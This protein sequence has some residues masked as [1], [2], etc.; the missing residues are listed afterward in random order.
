MQNVTESI[1]IKSSTTGSVIAGSGLSVEI[2]LKSTGLPASIFSDSAGTIPIT[3]PITADDSGTFSF[4]AADGRYQAVIS[5]TGISGTVTKEFLL[6]DVGDA[7]PLV[8]TTVDATIIVATTSIDTPLLTATDLATLARLIAGDPGTEATGITINGVLYESTAKVSDIDGTHLAQTILHR[9]STVLEPLIVGARSNGN[10]SAHVDVVAGQGLFTV[11]AAGY[12]GTDYKLFGSFTFGA[13]TGTISNT[14]APGSWSL[15]L[16]PDGATFPV[17]VLALDNAGNI[18]APGFPKAVASYTH[19]ATNKDTPVDADEFNIWDSVTGLLNKVTFANLKA[20]IAA[21]AINIDALVAKTIPV[22]ADE[23]LLADSADTFAAKKLTWAQLKSTFIAQL[24][25][26][27]RGYTG[28]IDLPGN[29]TLQWGTAAAASG[30]SATVIFSK[31][32]G[33]SGAEYYWTIQ[34]SVNPGIAANVQRT[35]NLQLADNTG[36]TAYVISS[37]AS[38]VAFNWWAL[39]PTV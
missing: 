38:A 18:T 37:D 13:D 9:H 5:G 23:L 4:Y 24:I 14:S 32:F 16:T 36:F 25:T 30:A 33:T 26:V 29:I 35:V 17:S 28:Y 8:A 31:P 15:N 11:F 39:G 22:D 3:N 34:T 2:R 19:A 20:V 6:E 1:L 27:S 7:S 10:T 12:A 21:A